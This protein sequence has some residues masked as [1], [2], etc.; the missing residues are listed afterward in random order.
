MAGSV[1]TAGAVLG[2]RG[3]E[4]GFESWMTFA[5]EMGGGGG[6][7]M[8]IRMLQADVLLHRGLP[9]EALEALTGGRIKFL[10]WWQP[11]YLGTLAEVSVAAGSENAATALAQ[12]E[13]ATGDN[14]YAQ[15]MAVR[16]RGRLE[17]D[18]GMLR[19]ALA[20]FGEMECPYQAARTAW[21]LGGD[22]RAAAEGTL[23]RLGA[24][25]PG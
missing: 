11:M 18:E 24:T 8:G 3:D 15:A 6:Q 13:E 23:K 22:D 12:A 9:A 17:E 25:P 20:R 14:R 4:R 10:F 19:E 7:A 21:L 16:T 2:Y 1:A 5:E